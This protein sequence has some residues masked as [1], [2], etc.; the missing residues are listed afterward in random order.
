MKIRVLLL[1]FL[2]AF[3]SSAAMAFGESGCGEGT[4]ADCHSLSKEQAKDVLKEL[5]IP[6][7]IEKVELSEVPGLW[8]VIVKRPDGM[9]LP[10]YLDFSLTYMIQGEALKISTKENITRKM[11]IELNRTDTSKIPLGDAVVMGE[12]DA[13]YKIIVFDDPECPYCQKLQ[14][15]MKEITTKRKDIAFYIK[16][17]PLDSH[18]TAYD[19]AKAIICENS[20]ELL[21]KSLANIEIPPP[22]CETDVIEK[23]KKLA[24]ELRIGSTPTLI[25][26]DGRVMPVYKTAADNIKNLELDE[27][28]ND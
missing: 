16:M 11:V 13:K 6:I 12:R 28:F 15:S 2:L 14:V 3:S 27:T 10:I 22:T 25:F 5:K 23:N 9:M 18:P 24:K 17:L 19:K 8:S 7:E 21:E 26:P 20:L 4:C 1:A